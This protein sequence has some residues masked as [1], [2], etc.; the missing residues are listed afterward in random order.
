MLTKLCS[1]L[2]LLFS[3]CSFQLFAAEAERCLQCVD[4][5]G[6]LTWTKW[7]LLMTVTCLDVEVDSGHCLT[8]VTCNRLVS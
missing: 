3:D 4:T 2:T 7:S 8:V 5:G 1:V 6:H